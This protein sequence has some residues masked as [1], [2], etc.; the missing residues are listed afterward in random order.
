MTLRDYQQAAVD[1]VGVAIKSH[2]TVLIVAPTASGKSH[3]IAE[4]VRRFSSHG[5]RVLV[6]VHQS[7]IIEQNFKACPVEDKGIYC[8]GLK[9]KDVSNQVIF[10]SRDSLGAFPTAAGNF[11]VVLVDE[12]HAVSTSEKTRYHKIF[13]TV[14]P[15]KIVGL[16]ATPWRLDNGI[17]Y[18]AKKFWEKLAYDIPMRL[19]IERGYLSAYKFPKVEKLIDA[20]NVKVSSTGD[21]K[22]EELESVS[23]LPE[24]TRKAVETWRQSDYRLTM[25]FCCSVAHATAVQEYLG[26]DAKMIHAKTP[27][28]ERAQIIDDAR[29]GKVKVLVNVATLICGVDIP[30]IDCLVLLRATQSATLFVQAV[31]RALRIA[32]GKT[33]ATIYDFAGN[34]ERFLSLEEPLVNL[35][36]MKQKDKQWIEEE[37]AKHGITDTKL[38]ASTKECPSCS[39]RVA[40]ARRVCFCGHLFL[41]HT[42][43][44]FDGIAKRYTVDKTQTFHTRTSRGEQCVIVTYHTAEIGVIKE[45]L[46]PHARDFRRKKATE[47]LAQLKD[48]CAQITAKRNQKGFWQVSQIFSTPS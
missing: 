18:G 14:L 35:K 32:P 16:T 26:S 15:K 10:A 2:K 42:S 21:Y 41:N 19:L 38:E 27:L 47:R 44:Y 13:E 25:F 48:G 8:A 17:V 12:A 28:K 23:N 45:W 37:L 7:E 4:I 30:I 5:L 46:F 31:G 24:V 3:I 43:D 29:N 9:R 33:V 36:G 11:A 22:I 6:L 39:E 34:F 1:S 40:S 20:D